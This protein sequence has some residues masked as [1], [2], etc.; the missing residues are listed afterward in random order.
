MGYT[1]LGAF[2]SSPVCSLTSKDNL[3]PKRCQGSCSHRETGI[4]TKWQGSLNHENPIHKAPEPAS[5]FF[6][7][8]FLSC[9]LA[10]GGNIPWGSIPCTAAIVSVCW[11]QMHCDHH[12]HIE[13]SLSPYFTYTLPFYC[14]CSSPMSPLLHGKHHSSFLVEKNLK[15]WVPEEFAWKHSSLSSK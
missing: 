1:H 8:S 5:T 4:M 10:V 15:N 11:L 14:C 9:F 12:A 3:I 6:L 2:G 13:M 7:R